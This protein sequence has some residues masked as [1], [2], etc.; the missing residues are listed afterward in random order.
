MSL[1]TVARNAFSIIFVF[2]WWVCSWGLLVS[3][4]FFLWGQSTVQS[5]SI[6][7]MIIHAREKF[8]F[9]RDDNDVHALVKLIMKAEI[10]VKMNSSVILNAFIWTFAIC[11]MFKTQLQEFTWLRLCQLLWLYRTVCICSCIGDCAEIVL[12][13]LFSLIGKSANC[14]VF[15]IAE[16]MYYSHSKRSKT[17]IKRAMLFCIRKSGDKWS[18]R[19]WIRLIV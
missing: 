8:F 15:T 5:D 6:A 10:K 2:L 11:I 3:S 9:C 18:I 16:K 17:C 19:H 7:L 12:L 14:I 4:A 13:C 1:Y